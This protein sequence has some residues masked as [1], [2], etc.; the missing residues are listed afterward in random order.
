MSGGSVV[1]ETILVDT[2]ILIDAGRNSS[3]ALEILAQIELRA[4][5][6]IS[7]ITEM[8]LV[9][10][11]RNKNEMKA[12]DNFLLRFQSIAMDLLRHYNLSHGL[13]VP[14]ALIAATAISMNLALITK[15]IRDYR[16]I[17]E[18]RVLPYPNLFP[19]QAQ[20]AEQ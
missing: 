4:T 10:G 19:N 9:V 13:L 8:E 5:L 7:A 12:L 6:A 3:D 18:L 16:F 2:D 15:N 1:S 17:K 11:L 20:D 14:D